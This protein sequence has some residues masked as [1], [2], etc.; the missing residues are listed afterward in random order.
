MTSISGETS[1]CRVDWGET[2]SEARR[3]GVGGRRRRKGKQAKDREGRKRLRLA[4]EGKAIGEGRRRLKLAKDGKMKE[5]EGRRR[6]GR[7]DKGGKEEDD[8]GRKEDG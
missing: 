8:I 1:A 6:M 4:K 5:R 2:E 7:E 3:G